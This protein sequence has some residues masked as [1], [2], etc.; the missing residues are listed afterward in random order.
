MAIGIFTMAGEK[1]SFQLLLEVCDGVLQ[2]AHGDRR[3][4]TPRGGQWPGDGA[5]RS[6]AA[7]A[8]RGLNAEGV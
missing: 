2:A 6:P 3:V 5:H 7:A 1:V 8:S 4:K